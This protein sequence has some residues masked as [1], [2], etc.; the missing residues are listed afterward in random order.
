MPTIG[1]L[2][3]PEYYQKPH[4]DQKS[5]FGT[6]SDILFARSEEQRKLQLIKE[7]EEYK[8][9]L[10]RKKEEDQNTRQMKLFQMAMEQAG[11]FNNGVTRSEV[12]LSNPRVGAIT[13]KQKPAPKAA[14]MSMEDGFEFSTEDEDDDNGQSEYLRK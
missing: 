2:I 7:Q 4:E 1:N 11:Q 9:Q 13:I 3:N 12:S 10:E 6:L 8:L 5:A 14:M